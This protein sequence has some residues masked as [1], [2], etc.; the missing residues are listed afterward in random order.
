M[1]AQN[2]PLL[3]FNSKLSIDSAVCPQ[4]MREH[5]DNFKISAETAA[6]V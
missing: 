2:E 1:L 6:S 3:R 4:E 5:I